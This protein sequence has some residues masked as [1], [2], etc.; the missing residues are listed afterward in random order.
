MRCVAYESSVGR[1]SISLEWTQR[2]GQAAATAACHDSASLAG[3]QARGVY[4]PDVTHR[5]SIGGPLPFSCVVLA[6]T[7][8]GTVGANY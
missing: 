4:P 6:V 1:W 7:Q 5:L 3:L 2:I 8:E